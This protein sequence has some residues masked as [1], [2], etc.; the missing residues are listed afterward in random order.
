MLIELVS[1]IYAEKLPR[2]AEFLRYQAS[3]LLLHKPKCDVQL[4]VCYTS[5]DHYTVNA[6]EWIRSKLVPGVS[7]NLIPM[8]PAK[9]FRRSIGRNIAALATKADITWF[10]DIDHCF[11]EGCLDSLADLQWPR[12]TSLVY[13]QNIMIQNSWK[14]GDETADRSKGNGN[15]L[16]LCADD[17]HFKKLHK[18]I[19]GVQIV[20]GNMAREKGYLNGRRQY[21]SLRNP[22]VPWPDFEDDI[23]FRMHM[24]SLGRLRRISIPNMFRMRH[25]Q[26]S[27]QKDKE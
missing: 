27:Y 22:V 13:P 11:Y 20:Q 17:F 2:F 21:Q 5:E 25:T 1:H 18:A 10:A 6:I 15:L 26:T 19:G 8:I 7:L 24:K 3:S 16:E 4:T 14:L 9:L 12:R 23:V